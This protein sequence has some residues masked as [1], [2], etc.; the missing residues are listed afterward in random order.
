MA[1]IGQLVL[2]Q[3]TWQGRTVVGAD[4]IQES[5]QRATR[6]VRVWAGHSFDYG[7]LWWI[8]S[9]AGADIVTASGALG[10]WIFVSARHQLV[11]ASTA[12][13]DD[14]RANA[15]VEFLFSHVLPA[16]RE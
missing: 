4:W 5:T 15:A 16:V 11:V 6:N 8:T 14:S 3:G 13:N 2:D 10:Q 1:K 12:D 9:D 7:Y